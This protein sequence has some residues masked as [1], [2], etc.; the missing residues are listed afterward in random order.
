[1]KSGDGKDLEFKLG[2][3][4]LNFGQPLAIDIGGLF[5]TAGYVLY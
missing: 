2:E 4:L 5:D 3:S 1:M